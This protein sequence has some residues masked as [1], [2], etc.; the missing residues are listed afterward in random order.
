MQKLATIDNSTILGSAVP[1]SLPIRTP[2]FDGPLALLIKFVQEKRITLLDV[3]LAPIANAYLDYLEET[4][5][6]DLDSAGAALLAIAYLLERKAELLLPQP[7]VIIQEELPGLIEPTSY[8]FAPAIETL[9]NRF[10]NR[11]QLFFRQ[12][13]APREA[14]QLPLDIG[15][16]TANSLAAALKRLLEAAIPPKFDHQPN[17]P[18]VSLRVKMDEIISAL[19]ATD[20]ALTLDSLLPNSFTRLD[21]VWTFLAILELVKLNLIDVLIENENLLLNGKDVT[22]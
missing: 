10:S 13:D 4:D 7:S 21:V 18:H 16:L 6:A 11:Q 3:P 22:K 8:Y 12:P 14:Y 5:C 17:R 15:D 2:A 1:P 9:E 20:S 19:S